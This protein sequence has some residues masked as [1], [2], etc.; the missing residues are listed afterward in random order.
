[1]KKATLIIWVIIFGFI[2]L[3]IFQNQDFFLAKASFRINLGIVQEYMSPAIPN[4]VL[5]LLFFFSGLLISYLFGFS[6]RFKAKRTV[7]RLNANIATQTK[8]VT[9]LKSELDKLKGIE[10]PVDSHADTVKLDMNTTQQIPGEASGDAA[11]GGKTANKEPDK[12]LKFDAAQETGNPAAGD[13]DK[14]GEKKD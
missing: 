14:P 5:I 12:T 13:K 10:E 8:E 1:M 7:K 9:Q 11:A 4:A 6:S 3:V 2:A